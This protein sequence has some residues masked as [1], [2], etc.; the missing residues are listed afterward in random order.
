VVRKYFPADQVS[1]AMAVARC[2]SGHANRVGEPNDNG[3]RDFG[4][5]QVN[6]GGTLQAALKRIG[7][8]FSDVDE[9]RKKALSTVINVR[10]ARAIWETRGWQPWVCAAKL[11]IVAGPYQR[12]PGPMAGKYDEYGRA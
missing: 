12:N 5:F 8:K 2:E 11:Q 7:V 1:N 9:A 6:D 10:A 4:V 3:T